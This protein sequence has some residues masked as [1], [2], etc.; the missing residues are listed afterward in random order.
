M[1]LTGHCAKAQDSLK[2][3]GEGRVGTEGVE[4]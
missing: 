4:M 2:E 1:A 3:K